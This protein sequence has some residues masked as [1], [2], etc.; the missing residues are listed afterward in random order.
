MDFEP[1]YTPEQEAFRDEVKGW[2]KSHV[3]QIEGDPDSDENYA[4]YRELGG[5]LGERGWLRAT[6]APE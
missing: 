3:P 2:L 6:A 4:Q 1:A 5:Q